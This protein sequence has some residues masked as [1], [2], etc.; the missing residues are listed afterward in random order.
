[1]VTAVYPDHPWKQWKFSEK[2]PR[3]FWI[4]TDNQRA[5]LD[6]VAE[7]LGIRTHDEWYYI[8]KS[9]LE[10]IGGE[11]VLKSYGGLASLLI[12]CYPEYRWEMEMF[13]KARKTKMQLY[14]LRLV[15]E[16]LPDTGEKGV[17]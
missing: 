8:S 4:N 17:L 2:L 11:T 12:A 10:E 6:Y 7:K 3:N 1:M 16:M 9:A 14:V 13:E 15:Q 5:F